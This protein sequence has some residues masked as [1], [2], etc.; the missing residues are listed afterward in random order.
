[1]RDANYR[2]EDEDEKDLQCSYISEKKVTLLQARSVSTYDQRVHEGGNVVCAFHQRQHK[3]YPGAPQQY[4]DQLVL[5]LLQN[6]LPHWRGWL[7]GKCCKRP[8]AHLFSHFSPET[9]YCPTATFL[10]PTIPSILDVCL[11]YLLVVQPSMLVDVEIP[12]DLVPGLCVCCLHVIRRRG[13]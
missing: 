10:L 5:K 2:I 3:G 4:Q 6:Q 12:Q 8:L 9:L 11:C 1:M 13:V 7:F